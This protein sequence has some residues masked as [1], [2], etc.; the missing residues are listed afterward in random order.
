MTQM[1]AGPTQFRRINPHPGLMID[2]DVWQD[3]HEYHRDQIRLHHLALHGWGIVQGLEVTP[4][5]GAANTVRIGRGIGIDAGGNFIIV[6]EPHTYQFTAREAATIY[7]VLQFRDVPVDTST[8]AHNGSTAGQPNRLVEA[9]R[10]QERD[11]LPN[12]PYLELARVDFEP[13]R[14][15]VR[16]PQ[17]PESAG[18]NEL[19]ARFRVVLGAVSQPPLT[20][21]PS[22]PAAAV[23]QAPELGQLG[24]QI[25]ALS[26]RVESLTRGAAA[27]PPS[28][29]FSPPAPGVDSITPQLQALIERVDALADS[30]ASA[31]EV[32]GTLD[33]VEA[34]SRQLDALALQVA[35]LARSGQATSP[36]LE[37]LNQR[38]QALGQDLER[39]AADMATMSN[40]IEAASSAGSTVALRLAVAEHSA[41]G[42]DSHRAGLRYLSR[43]LGLL[44]GLRP[45]VVDP[46]G[47]GNSEP[48]DVVFVSGHAALSFGDRE[49]QALADML[50]R[51]G[52]VVGEGCAAGPQGE[53]GAREFALSFV[54]LATRLGRQLARVDRDHPVMAARHLFG[55]PPAGARATPRVLEAGGMVYSDAD[56]GCVWQG[57]AAE[58]PLPRGT[59]RDAL[60]FGTNLAMY[61]RSANR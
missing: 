33:R 4:V 39:R 30:Q 27:L 10:I 35:D 13:K 61:R 47:L 7:L 41:A 28:D 50:E 9:Y 12:E 38:V 15:S 16:T 23:A 45:E 36:Q 60:E 34:I 31:P 49:V 32:R 18:Q 56:Y 14:G 52:V 21:A 55:E 3:A 19:D 20:R 29:V 2:V 58:R 46:I 11:R 17:K 1:Q 25:A 37:A 42:W 57:G 26:Q 40:R 54:D 44:D 43:E 5:A 51:G 59:I 6:P 48:A 53:A 24:A 8:P 22:P